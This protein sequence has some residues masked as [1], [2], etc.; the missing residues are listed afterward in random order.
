M[1]PD[2]SAM[3]LAIDDGDDSALPDLADALEEAGDKRAEGLRRIC[4]DSRFRCLAWP[5]RFVF[6]GPS[7]RWSWGWIDGS[8]PPHGADASTFFRSQLAESIYRRL[9]G[10]SASHTF[11]PSASA[12]T[13]SRAKVYPTRSAAYLALAAALAE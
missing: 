7:R 4:P 11:A 2:M 12:Y 13:A 6:H 5:A 10:R 1:T 3:C 8:H 9:L